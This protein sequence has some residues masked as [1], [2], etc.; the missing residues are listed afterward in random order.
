M[1]EFDWQSYRQ[2]ILALRQERRLHSAVLA[3]LRE[4]LHVAFPEASAVSEVNATL[5][6]RNDAIQFFHDG[7]RTVFELFATA[8]QVPQ[9]LRL[10][11]QCEADA[12]VAILVDREVDSKVSDE[13][14]RKRPNHFP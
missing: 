8:S 9:D 14:F 7:R 2:Q 11:E 1:A 12:R 5:G 3:R 4:L 13:F 6:G 10:L